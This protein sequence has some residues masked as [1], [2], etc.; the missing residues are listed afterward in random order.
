VGIA[1]IRKV[2]PG[3][4]SGE[5]NRMSTISASTT[6]SPPMSSGTGSDDGDTP[7]AMIITSDRMVKIAATPAPMG[8][9]LLG[10][11]LER[12]RGAFFLGQ[13]H[14]G[15]GVS[16]RGH[17]GTLRDGRVPGLLTVQV[18]HRFL[19]LFGDVGPQAGPFAAF[20]IVGDADMVWLPTMPRLAATTTAAISPTG[21]KQVPRQRLVAGH[22]FAFGAGELDRR[23]VLGAQEGKTEG[24]G[25]IETGQEQPRQQRRL[26]QRAHRQHRRLTR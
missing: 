19:A 4:V 14:G 22:R 25:G 13:F 5:M 3:P 26:E 16:G 7:R 15:A 17:L 1:S 21:R 6:P 23:G 11:G 2:A 9:A 10:R 12:D 20:G 8:A 18:D 24:V